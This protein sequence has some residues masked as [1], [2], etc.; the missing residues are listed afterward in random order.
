MMGYAQNETRFALFIRRYLKVM[1]RTENKGD[2]VKFA[3]VVL[4]YLKISDVEF[5]FHKNIKE[6]AVPISGKKLN[7]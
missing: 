4:S 7:F 3:W 6:E 1:V 2:L 5:F